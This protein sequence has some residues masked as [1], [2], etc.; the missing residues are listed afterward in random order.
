MTMT[1]KKKKLLSI[2]IPVGV[3]VIAAIV[4]A[5]VL[6]LQNSQPKR[7]LQDISVYDNTPQPVMVVEGGLEQA[8][9]PLPRYSI[10]EQAPEGYLHA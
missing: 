10:S 5:V 9:V 1:K 6:I 3:V 2:L 4:V 7:Y 8:L